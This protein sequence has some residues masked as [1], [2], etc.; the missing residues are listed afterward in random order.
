MSEQ[1]ALARLEKIADIVDDL[2]YA[3]GCGLEGTRTARNIREAVDVLRKRLA[4][5]PPNAVEADRRRG[6][7]RAADRGP[8]FTEPSAPAEP[9][10]EER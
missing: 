7:R 1:D 4:G 5:P 3:V 2:A 9:N 10:E 6:D 8:V